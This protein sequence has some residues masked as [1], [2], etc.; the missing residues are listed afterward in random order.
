[1]AT[2]VNIVEP[3][4]GDLVVLARTAGLTVTAV[5]PKTFQGSVDRSGT[6]PD[7]LVMD[8]RQA[9]EFPPELAVFKRR[10]PRSGIV[11]VVAALDPKMMRDAMRAGVTELVPEPVSADDLRQAIESVV[12]QQ[13]PEAEHGKVLAFMGAKGGVGT[14][15]L[16]VNVAAALAAEPG[17]TVL[18]A[19]LHVTGHGDAALFLGV[20]PRFSIA[21]AL[22]NVNRLDRAVLH[23]LVARAKC[24]VDVL[25]SPD[26][27]SMRNPEGHQIGALLERVSKLYS[28]VVIDLPQSDLGAI[29]AIEPISALTLV[30]N[31]ELPTVRRASR[32][33]SLLRQRYGKD[34]VHMVVSRYDPRAE[35]GQEDIERVVD[36]PVSAVVPSDYRRAVAAA[37]AG[38][39]IVTDQQNRLAKVIQQL[40]RRLAGRAGEPAPLR[41]VAKAAGRFGG[42]F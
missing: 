21:D 38:E 13:A 22:E 6:A 31:Q 18:M 28:H 24:R 10:H 26:R 2:T 34:R 25:A 41:N 40:A 37:N 35:I 12:G 7:V 42:M 19:D 23:S 17:T 27:P 11:I 36:L 14:T 16:A 4:N 20:E 32:V 33:A 29:D 9:A 30:V 1:L 15:T 5:D 39:P 3:A 8:L